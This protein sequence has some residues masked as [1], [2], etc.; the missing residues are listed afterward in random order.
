MGDQKLQIYLKNW[1]VSFNGI[2]F[3]GFFL[4]LT[5][6]KPPF[7]AST[8]YRGEPE[9]GANF[10]YNKMVTDYQVLW[11][12]FQE[13]QEKLRIHGNEPAAVEEDYTGNN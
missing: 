3:E 12:L 13:G 5:L 2:Y 11:Q 7:R 4:N 10:I 1:A 6:Y 8:L 9:S